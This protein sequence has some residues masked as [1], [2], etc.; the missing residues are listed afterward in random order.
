LLAYDAVSG[1]REQGTLRLMLSGTAARYQVLLGKLL[2]G[3]LVLV[4]A[5]A[6]AFALG[7]VILLCL[8]MVELTG[9]DWIRIGLMFLASLVFIATMYN[10]GLLF[11]VWRGGPPFRSSSDCSCGLFCG[12]HSQRQRLSGH[13]DPAH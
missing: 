13:A 1:E 4:V 3:L 5:V 7:L 6:I 10:L 12:G 8:P 11:P 2:A 9:S